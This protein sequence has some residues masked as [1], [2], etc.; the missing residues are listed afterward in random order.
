MYIAIAYLDSH[1]KSEVGARLL[2]CI[3]FSVID[4]RG[5]KLLSLT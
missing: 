5:D 3:D 1:I 4:S 2:N